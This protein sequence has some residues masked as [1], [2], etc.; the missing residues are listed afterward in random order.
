MEPKGLSFGKP[1][2]APVA[3]ATPA[4]SFGVS[5]GQPPAVQPTKGTAMVPFTM[6]TV[7]DYGKPALTSASAITSKINASSRAGDIDE[8]GKALGELMQGANQYDPKH[9]KGF[10]GFFR[11]KKRD[12]EIHYKSVDAN[13]QTL[14]NDVERQVDLFK[15]RVDDLH[16]LRED[17]RQ[18]HAALGAA[19]AEGELRVAWMKENPPQVDVNDPMQASQIKTW[20]DV[21]AYA[22]KRIDDFKRAQVMAEMNDAQID[23]MINNA[24]ALVMTFGEIKITTLPN[25]Q[26]GFALYIAN[27]EAEKGAEFATMIHDKNNDLM[28]KNADK[29]GT[30][31]VKI[32]QAMSRSSIDMSTL[33]HVRDKFF[34]TGEKMKQI[35]AETAQRLKT[36]GPQAQ[37]ISQ[38][39]AARLAAPIN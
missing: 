16:A 24:N 36:E 34:E 39:L 28:K 25:L 3:T 5:A 33:V 17:N 37:A 29:L 38:E 12:L 15:A 20:N 11:R 2:A 14:A 13:V 35:Q 4:P 22:E 18:R 21:I 7:V 9:L 23:M 6:Q 31:T 32:G 1:A 27:M 10:M 19:A 8:V 26:M 30:A